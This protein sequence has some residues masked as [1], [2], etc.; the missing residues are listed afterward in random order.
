MSSVDFVICTRNIKDGKFGDDPG[1]TLLL[2]VPEDKKPEPSQAIDSKKWVET[3]IAEVTASSGNATGDLLVFIHGYNS[4]PEIVMERHRGL[5]NNL[6]Q[7]GFKGT[8]VSFD[9]PSEGNT[10]AYIIDRI[11]AK[12]TALQL[13][14]DG[15]SL[16]CKYQQP[17]CQINVHIL[18]HSMGA[19][20]L[21]EAF[22]DADDRLSLAT[23]NWKVSQIML[24]GADISKDSL[25]VDN[26]TTESLYRHCTRLT[27]YSNSHDEVL[28]LS[29]VKRL[30]VAPRVGRE[31]L[32]KKVPY[33]AVNVNCGD[34]WKTLSKQDIK[35]GYWK[36]S[37]H[38]Y[39]LVFIEDL[40]DTVKGVHEDNMS[41]R[42]T[43]P[44]GERILI[45]T[46]ARAQKR[47][48]RP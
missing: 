28:N 43:L 22:D 39:D 14:S 12:Q 8:V 15:I 1:K 32:P 44:S 24:I 11:H 34:Y 21:R 27:N 4:N 5:K 9:W 48:E 47:I 10:L 18:A 46:E 29:N 37:W 25:T 33:H 13:V 2:C 42:K 26:S 36:H 16:L 40:F 41:T 20:V 17:N 31:G 7:Q 6:K 45:R 30:G 38:F 3:L 19:F 35:D 23:L